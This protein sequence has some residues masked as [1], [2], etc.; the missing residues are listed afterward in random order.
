MWN[1]GGAAAMGKGA[2]YGQKGQQQQSIKPQGMNWSKGGAAIKGGVQKQQLSRQQLEAGLIE[3]ADGLHEGALD[4]N[5]DESMVEAQFAQLKD[6]RRALLASYGVPV[7]Q[8][9]KK[10]V[11]APKQQAAGNGKQL[12]IFTQQQNTM[13]PVGAVADDS[14]IQWKSLLAQACVKR[15]KVAL[16]KGEFVYET[17]EDPSGGYVSTVSSNSGFLSGQYAGQVAAVSKKLAENEAAKAA[18]EVEFPD[19]FPTMAATGAMPKASQNQPQKRKHAEITPQSV[20]SK[21]ELHESIHLL[22]GRAPCKEDIV[23]ETVNGEAGGYVSTVRLPHYD[24][25]LAWTGSEAASKKLAEEAASQI[26]LE[27]LASVIEPL[28]DEHRQ[29]KAKLNKERIAALKA[30]KDQTGAMAPLTGSSMAP[31]TAS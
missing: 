20:N 23:Y 24:A 26:A 7:P 22:C 19:I 14:Q 29:K 6:T 18:L 12:A 16:P 1:K 27:Q 10:S 2:G 9:P 13:I 8:Q 30:R 11:N 15:N 31:L 21:S 17:V 28:K 5:V 3:L 25:M 4:L